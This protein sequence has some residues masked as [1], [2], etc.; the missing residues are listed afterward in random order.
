MANTAR[1]TDKARAYRRPDGMEAPL[2]RNP[3]GMAL[4]RDRLQ[5]SNRSNMQ[6]ESQYQ[7][8][9]E[10]LDTILTRLK[11]RF[12]DQIEQV[13]AVGEWA[14]DGID[15]GDLPLHDVLLQIVTRSN[16][17]SFGLYLAIAHEVFGDLRDQDILVQFSLLTR[18]EWQRAQ[19][20][21]QVRPADL[22]IPLLVRA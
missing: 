9:R 15:L 3:E 10:V 20:L 4:L 17:R 18:P 21:A 12:E 6:F 2:R 19:Q 11:E 22:G 7:T 8:L 1:K 14:E 16:E 5:A 13:Q